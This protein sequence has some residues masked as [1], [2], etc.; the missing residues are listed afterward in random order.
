M[1]KRPEVD[2]VHV[3]IRRYRM[4]GSMEQLVSKVATQFGA[5]L[6]ADGRPQATTPVSV[7]EGI[8]SYQ[9]VTT[10]IDT[11]LTITVFDSAESFSRAQDS[12][13]AI[14]KS[15]SEFHVD[16]VE[17]LSGEIVISHVRTAIQSGG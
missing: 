4:A 6:S 16:E 7:P 11:L 14:R 5:Q 9:A 10:G 8:L 3:M 1:P 13:A 17:T 2:P 12:A 15:L